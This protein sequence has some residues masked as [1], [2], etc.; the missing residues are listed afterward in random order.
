MHSEK[1]LERE[2]GGFRMERL[3]EL[4]VARTAKGGEEN[5]RLAHRYLKIAHDISRHYKVRMPERMRNQVCKECGNLLVP[6]ANCT[7]RVVSGGFLAYRCSCGHTTRRF[8]RPGPEG[9]A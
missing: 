3:F 6:G 2:I 5:L 1:R 9:V 8:L 4:A 7:V